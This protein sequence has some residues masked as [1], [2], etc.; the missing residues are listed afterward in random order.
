[1]WLLVVMFGKDAMMTLGFV[2]GGNLRKHTN[3]SVTL[4]RAFENV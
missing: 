4:S 2:L 1:M 3:E